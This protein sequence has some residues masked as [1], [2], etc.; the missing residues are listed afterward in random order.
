MASQQ[1]ENVAVNLNNVVRG[2]Q[3]DLD[4]AVRA[5]KFYDAHGLSTE[6]GGLTS[7]ETVVNDIDKERLQTLIALT[8]SLAYYLRDLTDGSGN[9]ITGDPQLA[10]AGL[11]ADMQETGI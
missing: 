3:N 7:G 9:T 5:L 1:L 4:I 2:I 6:V 8:A 10:P 11:Q